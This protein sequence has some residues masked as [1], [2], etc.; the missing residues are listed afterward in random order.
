MKYINLAIFVMWSLGFMTGYSWLY[1]DVENNEVSSYHC[2]PIIEVST[3]EEAKK[4]VELNRS[5]AGARG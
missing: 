1:D 3:M 4:R 2:A 5:V